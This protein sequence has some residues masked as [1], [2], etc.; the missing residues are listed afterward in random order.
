MFKVD[1]GYII[2]TPGMRELQ[3]W[4]GDT[5]S[6]FGDIEDLANS[7][8]FSDCNHENEPGC[9]VREAIEIGDLKEERLIS[10]RKQRREI[11]NMENKI[12]FGHKYAERE[13]IKTMM[14][15]LDKKKVNH[16]GRS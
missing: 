7:C 10:Y 16:R 9:A 14:G 15:F 12:N 1:G 8:R 2:D 5:S 11:A 4:G 6:T 13:K 3:F